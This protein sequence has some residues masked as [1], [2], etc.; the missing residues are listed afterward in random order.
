MIQD[1]FKVLDFELLQSCEID[2]YSQTQ[3]TFK[4]DFAIEYMI[5]QGLSR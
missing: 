3:I 2:K 1:I 4:E 5:A